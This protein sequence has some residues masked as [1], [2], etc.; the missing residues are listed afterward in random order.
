MLGLASPGSWAKVD[1]LAA[2]ISGRFSHLVF[3]HRPHHQTDSS[4]ANLVRWRRRRERRLSSRHGAGTASELGISTCDRSQ[5]SWLTTVASDSHLRLLSHRS[6][7]FEDEK[8]K[9][10]SPLCFQCKH[11][12]IARSAA[13]CSSVLLQHQKSKHYR[14]PQCPRRLNTAGGLSVHLT[15]VHK[16]EPDR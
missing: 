11:M 3:H 12:L 8:G 4:H 16:A 1:S 9:R 10:H 5:I 14:C 13:L 7:E 6:R 2:S 15:Q